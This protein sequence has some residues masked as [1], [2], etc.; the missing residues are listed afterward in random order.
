[1]AGTMPG[2]TRFSGHAKVLA[3]PRWSGLPAAPENL[4]IAGAPTWPTSFWRPGG[5]YSLEIVYRQRPGKEI[6]TGD[7]IPG[8][9]RVDGPGPVPIARL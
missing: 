8:P 5:I 6:L 7:W 2:D 4:E 9:R 1:V 3:P